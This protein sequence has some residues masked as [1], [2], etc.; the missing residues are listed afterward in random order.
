[1]TAGHDINYLSQ[2]GALNAIGYR[3]RPPLPPLN[4][5]ADFGGGSM[6]ALLGITAALYERE[7]S[8]LGQVIDVAMV[9]GVSA[10]AQVHWEFKSASTMT[11]GGVAGLVDGSTPFYASYETSDGK[12]MA[13]GAVEPQFFAN[14]LAGL[15]LSPADVPGQDDRGSFDRM[16]AVFADRFATKTRDEWARVFAGSDACVSPV[17]SWTEAVASDHLRARSTIV[18][19]GGTLQAAPA[20]RFSR[21]T[22]AEI[23]VPPTQPTAIDAIDW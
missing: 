4:L 19:R 6:F 15:G 3:D 17:L 16:R 9:D 14:L 10:L 11:D 1:M 7:Q 12:F 21:T 23:G 5:V 20:P 18:E 8:G 2:T 22:S 13:V